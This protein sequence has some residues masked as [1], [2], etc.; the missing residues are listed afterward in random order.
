M[1]RPLSRWVRSLSVLLIVLVL[2]TA[3][4]AAAPRG[5]PCRLLPTLPMGMRCRV[6]LRR[7]MILYLHHYSNRDFNALL[8]HRS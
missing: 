5:L 2:G 8:S 7:Q 6:P 4:P 1:R 3:I